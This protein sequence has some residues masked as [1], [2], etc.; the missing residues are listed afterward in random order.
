MTFWLATTNKNKIHEIESFFKSAYDFYHISHLKNYTPPEEIG[1]TFKENARI[2]AESLAVF[3]DKSEV[4]SDCLILGEDS[5]LKVYSLGGEPGIY[6]AR[7]SGPH[8]DDKQN[9]QL[10]LE[11]MKEQRNREAYYV[12]VICCLFKNQKYFFK[13]Q[14]K[15]SI[16]LEEKGTNGFGYDPLFIPEGERKTLGELPSDFKQTIS[17]RAKALNKLKD[18]F[19][20]KI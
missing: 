9:N 5:G 1:L 11:N 12:C 3:L 20:G 2:K 18:C 17:H 10:L 14:L 7:Y 6:S 15:G 8:G 13:G 4:S 19:L 16:A